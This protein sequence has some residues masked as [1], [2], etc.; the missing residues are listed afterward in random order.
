[1]KLLS[2]NE[3]LLSWESKNDAS[4]I[5]LIQKLYSDMAREFC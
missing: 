3:S 2:T 1:M 5:K 4:F